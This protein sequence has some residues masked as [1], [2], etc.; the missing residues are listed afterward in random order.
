[1]TINEFL[2]NFEKKDFLHE[3]GPWMSFK[4]F[5]PPFK[6]DELRAMRKQGIIE[7]EES[8][9]RFRL[10]LWAWTRNI[11]MAKAA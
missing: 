5:D 11:F 4:S 1:M 3:K 6:R 2:A 8:N 9:K 10:T 7:L